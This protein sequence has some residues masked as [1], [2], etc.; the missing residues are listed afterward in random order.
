TS[1]YNGGNFSIR[2]RYSHGLL[3][4][5]AYTVGHAI[6][7]ADSF[8]AAASDWWNLKLEKATAGYNANHK[9]ALS[10]VWAIPAFSRS[11][12]L[13]TITGGW[14][15]S[16]VTILQ[17]GSPFSV[18]CGTIF[19]PIRDA[20]GRITGNSGCDFNADAVAGDRPNAPS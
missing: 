8:S 17:S 1:S 7:Y 20:S 2:Q 16:G 9:L 3:F 19:T 15:L 13:K 5:A 4:Q 14:Q 11:S 18:S 12:M 6:N 10:A